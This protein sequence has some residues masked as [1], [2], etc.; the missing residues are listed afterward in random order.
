MLVCR[1][2]DKPLVVG[3]L[4]TIIGEAGINIANLMLGR[5]V[6]G[7]TA[8][9]VLNL[10]QD[11]PAEVMRQISAAPHILEARLVSLD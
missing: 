2:E 4:C 9:T 6:K 10:D 7:G 3:R 1:N 5:D 11:V 8:L